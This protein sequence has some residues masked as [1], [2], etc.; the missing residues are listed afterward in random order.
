MRAYDSNT[1]AYFGTPAVSLVRAYHASLREITR[2]PISLPARLALHAATAAR[3]SAAAAAL[4]LHPLCTDPHAQAHGMT[5]LWVPE[6]LGPTGAG[7]LLATM[8]KKGVV[9]AGGLVPAVKGRYI[10][11]GHMGWSVVGEGG[12]DVDL[13]I[14][15][16]GEAVGEVKGAVEGKGLARL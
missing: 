3:V 12:R 9:L 2:G 10:R 14:K 13:V 7:A 5:A 6:A 4:G 8:S 15:A 16:L 1:P 11:I